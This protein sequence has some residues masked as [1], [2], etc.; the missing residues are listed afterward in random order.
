LILCSAVFFSL[1]HIHLSLRTPDGKNA[2]AYTG[3]ESEG[4]PGAKYADTR[5][6]SEVAEHFLAGILD[7]LQDGKPSPFPSFVSDLSLPASLPWLPYIQ[8]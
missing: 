3:S 8:N 2:F 4:R 5:F 7:G 6:I 1:S